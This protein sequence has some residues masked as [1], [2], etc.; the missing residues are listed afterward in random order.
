MRK[1]CRL[2]Y[3]DVTALEQEED[4]VTG[5]FAY[6]PKSALDDPAY[7]Q[8][9]PPECRTAEGF[10][11]PYCLIKQ[12]THWRFTHIRDRQSR[13]SMK[14]FPAM[15]SVRD[16]CL[17][18]VALLAVWSTTSSMRTVRIKPPGL[19]LNLSVR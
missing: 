14:Y 15:I 19:L 10:L 1:F 2:W 9:A 13:Q 11:F 7:Q 12:V 4:N 18:K 6:L 8:R 3:D 17:V 16:V 5:V